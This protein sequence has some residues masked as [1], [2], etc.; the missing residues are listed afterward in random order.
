M[1]GGRLGDGLGLP[2][3]SPH[4]QQERKNVLEVGNEHSEVHCCKGTVPICKYAEQRETGHLSA[5]PAQVLEWSSVILTIAPLSKLEVFFSFL[6]LSTL[7][8]RA[9]QPLP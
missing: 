7:L 9:D 4:R 1:Q 5:T 2:D 6:S 3:L 8:Q